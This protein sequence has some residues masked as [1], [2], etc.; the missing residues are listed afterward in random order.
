MVYLFSCTL[1]CIQFQKIVPEYVGF[2]CQCGDTCIII[3]YL[4]IISNTFPILLQSCGQNQVKLQY[5]TATAVP[6]QDGSVYCTYETLSIGEI[7]ILRLSPRSGHQE[8]YYF[9][10]KKFRCGT[11]TD[12]LPTVQWKEVQISVCCGYS[13]QPQCR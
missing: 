10:A 9:S 3:N 8:Y 11:S 13:S 1:R 6:Q 2:M 7:I 4:I 12:Q 5:T